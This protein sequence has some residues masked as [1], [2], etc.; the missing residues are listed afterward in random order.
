MTEP[1]P[2]SETALSRLLD[3][4]R[5]MD[6][7]S[8]GSR[9]GLAD[10]Y[11]AMLRASWPMLFLMFAL[12]FIVFNLIFAFIY[13]FDEG[14]IFWGREPIDGGLMWRA[15]IFSIDTMTTVGY[16]NMAPISHFSNV[17][18]AIELALAMLFFALVT[19]MAFA[20]F[21]RPTARILF[22]KVAV[23][24]PFEGVPTLMLRCANQRHNMIFEANATMSLMVDELT[25]CGSMRRFYDLELLRR[26]TPVF[27]LTWTI[28]HPIDDG[29]PLRPWLDQQ[30]APAGSDLLIVVS[31]TDDRTGHVMYGR[32]AFGA[33]DLRWNMRFADVLGRTKQRRRKIDYRCFDKVVP[34]AE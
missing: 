2:T 6:V 16:G 34:L 1:A 13:S 32:H 20:R 30:A 8:L 24:A 4:N 3:S 7:R 18:S 17:V 31:G 33:D 11:H 12:S 25:E 14:G 15:F 21:S 26:S 5:R 28:M 29:S 22:S 10:L 23:I 27:A 9:S 19:G